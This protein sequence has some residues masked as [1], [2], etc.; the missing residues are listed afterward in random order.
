MDRD[1]FGKQLE[2]PHLFMFT[3]IK[4]YCIV[5]VRR[6]FA[7]EEYDDEEW[8]YCSMLERLNIIKHIH[9]HSIFCIINKQS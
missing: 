6:R 1:T 7:G 4:H 3:C 9:R 2:R 8:I 5:A